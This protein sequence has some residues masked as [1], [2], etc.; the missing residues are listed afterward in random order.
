MRSLKR[1]VARLPWCSSLCQ[2]VCLSVCTC[3]MGVHCDHTVHFSADLSLW[4]DSPVFWAPDTK[5]RPP[6]PSSL[7]FQFH[8]EERWGTELMHKL[9]VISQEGLKTEDKLLLSANICRVDWHNNGWPWMTLNGRFM[10]RQYRLFGR[11][12]HYEQTVYFT[13]DLTLWLD[14]PIILIPLC[15]Y[16]I[17]IRIARHL[18]GSWASCLLYSVFCSFFFR[19]IRTY[20]YIYDCYWCHL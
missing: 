6:T 2:S 13:T 12:M 16:K 14:S 8:L 4:L 5:A 17:I 11:D 15:H 10:V 1:I 18:C 9:G 19:I 20:C 3:G 7:I